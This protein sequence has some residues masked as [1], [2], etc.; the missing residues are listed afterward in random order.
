MT[1][2]EKYI[3]CHSKCEKYK[4]FRD[5]LTERNEQMRKAKKL[6]YGDYLGFKYDQI[7]KNRKLNKYKR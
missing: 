1:C 3:G 6:A 7:S 4:K 2:E 5:D